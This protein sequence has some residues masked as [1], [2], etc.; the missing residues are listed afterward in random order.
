[1]AGGI[2]GLRMHLRCGGRHQ[3]LGQHRKSD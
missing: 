2:G 1:V 3:K